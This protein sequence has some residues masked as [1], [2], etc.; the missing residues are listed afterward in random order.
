MTLMVS[1]VTDPVKFKR[2]QFPVLLCFA[3][4][5]NKN[6]GQSLSTVGVY[7]PKL[8]FTWTTIRDS[9]ESEEQT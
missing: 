4:T 9:I 8:V 6:Q 3:M 5:I 1:D 7:L 2:K